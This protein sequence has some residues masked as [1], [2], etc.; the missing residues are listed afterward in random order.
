[1]TMGAAAVNATIS[2]WFVSKRPGALAMAYNGAS[3]GGG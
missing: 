1:V 2:P 3:I